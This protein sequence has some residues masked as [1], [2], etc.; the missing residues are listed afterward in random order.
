MKRKLKKIVKNRKIFSLSIVLEEN[1]YKQIIS[2]KHWNVNKESKKI[3]YNKIKTKLNYS[4]QIR[5]QNSL[6]QT[7]KA[8]DGTNYDVKC[9]TKQR[10][11]CYG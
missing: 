4:R 3:T 1:I 6:T 2:I 9:C 10:I 11:H 8:T 7:G 5:L